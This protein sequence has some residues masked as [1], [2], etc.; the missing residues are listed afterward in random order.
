MLTLNGATL[1]NNFSPNGGALYNT[2]SLIIEENT[3]FENNRAYLG[4]AIYQA[5]SAGIPISITDTTFRRNIATKN[6]WGEDGIGGAIYVEGT[7]GAGLQIS[8]STITTNTAAYK[9]GAIYHADPDGNTTIYNTTLQANKSNMDG[10]AIYLEI[11]AMAII[12]LIFGLQLF[13]KRYN[14][15]LSTSR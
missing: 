3:L 2:G 13:D 4:G 14:T 5:G 12:D 10:G 11:G 7:D 9:G 1:Q 15:S 8:D 6:F